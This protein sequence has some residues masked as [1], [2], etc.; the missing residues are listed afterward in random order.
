MISC[1]LQTFKQYIIKLI[2]SIENSKGG[3]IYEQN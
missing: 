1:N 3:I 2:F